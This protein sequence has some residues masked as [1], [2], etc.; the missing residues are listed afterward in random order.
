MTS[1]VDGYQDLSAYSVETIDCWKTWDKL[2]PSFKDDSIY[3]CSD[4]LRRD[5]I[6]VRLFKILKRNEP[7]AVFVLPQVD[8]DTVYVP[9]NFIYNGLVFLKFDNNQNYAQSLSEEFRV[10]AYFL[11]Y[12]IKNYKNTHLSLSPT[13]TDIR[14]F[15]WANFYGQASVQFEPK[16][17]AKIALA[18]LNDLDFENYAQNALYLQ[19]NKSRR[20]S[21]RNSF[22]ER[23]V[24]NEVQN[25]SNFEKLYNDMME[26][27]MNKYE[28]P[29]DEI[30][31]YLKQLQHAGKLRIFQVQNSNSGV[32]SCAM[33]GTYRKKAFYLH[34][35]NAVEIR[36]TNA[37]TLLIWRILEKLF[38][39]GFETFDLEGINSPKRGYFK[40][41][42]G[43]KL[44]RYDQFRVARIIKQ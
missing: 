28:H 29:F 4:Y 16:F 17:T 30:K 31:N 2:V 13:V 18:G 40:L 37:G 7:R 19:F 44:V 20:Q 39:E 12:L 25:F 1:Y 26:K 6:D 3:W 34:G 33:I 36:N 11:D 41:S 9:N 8:N 42:F 35:A 21:L 32:V 24:F 14:P 22:N 43:A 23:L 10:T 5:N 27:M 38:T 15:D